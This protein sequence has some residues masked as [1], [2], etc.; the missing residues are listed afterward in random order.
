MKRIHDKKT[1]EELR[2]FFYLRG[3]SFYS[4]SIDETGK[5]FIIADTNGVATVSSSIGKDLKELLH[6]KEVELN[7]LVY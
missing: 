4:A 3:L 2:R 5:V 6:I 1:N 7:G